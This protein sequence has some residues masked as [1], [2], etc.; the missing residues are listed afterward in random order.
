MAQNPRDLGTPSGVAPLQK[1]KC[2]LYPVALTWNEN[3]AHRH[4]IRS[5]EHLH[6]HV[7]K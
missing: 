3:E 4:R 7:I 2:I 6:D 1:T 5:V